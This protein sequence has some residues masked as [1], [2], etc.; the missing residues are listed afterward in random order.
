MDKHVIK[1]GP[2]ETEKEKLLR[3]IDRKAKHTNV[4]DIDVWPEE[5]DFLKEIL[6]NA[7]IIE[8]PMARSG[9]IW[10]IIGIDEETAQ[11]DYHRVEP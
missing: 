11:A 1:W 7:Y 8:R 10:L 4:F 2:V 5:V 6:E 9:K 3:R